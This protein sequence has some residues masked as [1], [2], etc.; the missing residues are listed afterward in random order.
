MHLFYIGVSSSMAPK[1]A[2]AAVEEV[3]VQDRF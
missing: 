1:K 2:K 3:S